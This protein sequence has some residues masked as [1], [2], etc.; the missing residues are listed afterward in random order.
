MNTFLNLI[1]FR[2]YAKNLFIFLPIFFGQKIGDT[3]LLF[4]TF[5]VFVAFSLVAS[6]VYIFNDIFDLEED[7]RHDVKKNRP[8][9]SGNISREKAWIILVLFLLS[10]L[11]IGV[12]MSPKVFNL[13]ALYLIL[14]IFYTIRLKHIA[15][16]DCFIIATGF[17]I[18][19][20]VGGIIG[21]VELSVWIVLITF[22]LAL[23]LAFSKRRDDVRIYLSSGKKV[24]KVIDGYTLDFLNLSMTIMATVTLVS[25]IMYTVSQSVQS[26]NLY[27]TSV[28]VLLGILRYLQQTLVFGKSGSPTE[29]LLKDRFLQLVILG[30]IASFAV[31][32]YF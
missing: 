3:H 7:K 1:R 27:I 11:G 28:F 10:G 5:M 2:Q 26:N 29:V 20:F 6:S 8:L 21:S 19:I 14:N 18:R 15:I 16:L 12:Y 31:I 24:R 22:L 23:F 30:W 32:L 13:L 9:A 17:V 4:E 25:Y